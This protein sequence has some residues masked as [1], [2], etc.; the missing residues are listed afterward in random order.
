[1]KLSLLDILMVV[2]K[3]LKWY[4][5]FCEGVQVMTIVCSS[6]CILALTG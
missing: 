4:T 5:L 3:I 6:A 2:E 1:M